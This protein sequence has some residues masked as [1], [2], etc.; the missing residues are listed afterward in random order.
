MFSS[1]HISNATI[2][3]YHKEIVKR[4]LAWLHGYPSTLTELAL[5]MAQVGLEPI[6]S[7]KVITTGA[8]NL[9]DYQ[10]KQMQQAFPEAIV[11]TH[12]G[13]TEGVANMSQDKDGNWLVDEDFAYV[14]FVPVDE[15]GLCRIVG[16]G[17]S[18]KAFPLVRYDTGDLA[19]VRKVEGR[20]EI[21]SIEG[22]QTDFIRL[23]DGRRLGPLNQL[24]KDCL[25]IAAIQYV[26][27]REGDVR[28]KIV[29]G[30]DYTEKEEAHLKSNIKAR[31]DGDYDFPIEYV[32]KIE[33]T[34]SGKV[35]FVVSELNNMNKNTVITP[36]RKHNRYACVVINMRHAARP[37]RERR[38]A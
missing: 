29:R 17:F 16:T 12:Y 31:L 15:T 28:I 2:A 32:D 26:Q 20:D 38:A 22:R 14:E 18:N 9:T 13:L 11:R 36:P 37:A 35:R 27:N 25:N 19:I 34:K 7:V 3:E 30:A 33:R 8:E 10:I 5:T 23:K 24:T 1:Y 21:I 4:Q 6:R